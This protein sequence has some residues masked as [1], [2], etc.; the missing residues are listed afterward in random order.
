MDLSRKKIF[1]P[2]ESSQ[3]LPASEYLFGIFK[4]TLE[5]FFSLCSPSISNFK[6]RKWLKFENWPLQIYIRIIKH[7]IPIS[8]QVLKPDLVFPVH[9][10]DCEQSE[11]NVSKVRLKIPKRYSEAGSL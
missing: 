11:R 5:T 2:L 9:K 4:R 10:I 7:Y 8:I 1:N 3:R 6:K